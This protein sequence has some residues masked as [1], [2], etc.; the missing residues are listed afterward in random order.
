MRPYKRKGRAGGE[1]NKEN[2]KI[3]ASAGQ[4]GP[5]KVVVFCFAF[6]EPQQYSGVPALTESPEIIDNRVN[7]KMNERKRLKT[8]FVVVVDT[9]ALRW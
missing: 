9:I 2:E 5:A 6:H 3:L 7:K 8:D 4:I 1:R